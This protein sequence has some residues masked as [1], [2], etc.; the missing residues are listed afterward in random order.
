MGAASCQEQL[1]NYEKAAKIYNELLASHENRYIAPTALF[2]LGQVLERGNKLQKAKDEYARIVDD[3]PW[4]SWK[5]FA[6]KRVMLL[7]NFM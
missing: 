6:E 4:S 3:Y 5:D 2:N 1:K 7:R